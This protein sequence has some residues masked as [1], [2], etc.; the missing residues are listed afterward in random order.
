MGYYF[1]LQPLVLTDEDVEKLFRHYKVNPEPAVATKVYAILTEKE[2]RRQEI[3][4]EW[5]RLVEE[6]DKLL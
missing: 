5:E 2:R 6:Y 4:K 3:M 1:N